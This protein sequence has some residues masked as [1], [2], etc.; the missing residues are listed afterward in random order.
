MNEH[1][2][3]PLK[4]YETSGKALHADNTSDYFSA[5]LAKSGVNVE[6]NRATVR[7]F[8]AE[9]KKLDAINKKIFRFKA[10]RILSIIAI[11]IAVI[12]AICGI[13][14][15]NWIIL[16]L[17]PVVAITMLI[18]ILT[19]LTPSIRRSTE[20]QKILAE[21]ASKLF[22]TAM[23][24]MQ[25][26]NELFSSRDTFNIIEKT[27]PDINFNPRF[28]REEEKSFAKNYDFAIPDD[29]DTS[30]LRVVSGDFLKNPFV[31][32]RRL[33]HYLGTETYHGM[34]VISWTETETDS[35]GR[36]RT[37][38]RTQTL[39]ASLT[40][41]KPYYTTDTTLLFGSHAVP[42]LCFSRSPKHSENL[43]EKQL[44]KKIKKGKKKLEKK[45]R[46]SLKKG[47]SFQ[48]MAN[49]EF[50]VLFGVENRNNETQFR[51][52][53]TPLAQKN[54]VDII[55]SDTGYGDD[56]S[57]I[58]S[59]KL[60]IIRSEH[61]Q[62][63]AMS[64]SPANYR[65]HSVDLSKNKFESFNNEYFKSLFFD[66][67]PLLC[68]PV[69]NEE[70]PS[71]LNDESPLDCHF[72]KLEHEAMANS[73][74]D[75]DFAHPDSATEAILKTSV[76]SSDKDGDTVSV[77]AFSY[78]ASDRLDFVP[79]FGGDGHIH[80]VPVHWIEYIPIK[81]TSTLKVRF[82]NKDDEKNENEDALFNGLFA[83]IL[84]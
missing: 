11:V 53:Y 28:T 15:K 4:F 2:L 68:V 1:L 70:P 9:K 80:A 60:N 54:T 57:F 73:I 6:E 40:K 21:K 24:Q 75:A 41:P 65:S 44:E 49:T 13:V 48:E 27:L 42:E 20:I 84:K 33:K 64:T 29:E 61:M 5:L 83:S 31:F 22:D 58:K 12:A 32:C 16:A 56:F 67:A 14:I 34:L 30:A 78:S 72:A 45:A 77:T 26:L 37:V 38:R 23:Q 82:E 10:V 76:I 25:P 7:A 36:I 19:V 39:H 79:V 8:D 47:G 18:I 63:W 46:K 35:N 17:C 55:R 81:S 59:K 51:V 43:S 3:E 52:M 71:F 66:F 69:Y 74:R 50:E 62:S